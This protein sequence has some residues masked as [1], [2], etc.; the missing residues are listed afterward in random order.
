MA[1]LENIFLN[2]VLCL[3]ST[4]ILSKFAIPLTFHKLFKTNFGE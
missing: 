1:E 4:S 3:K 2:F